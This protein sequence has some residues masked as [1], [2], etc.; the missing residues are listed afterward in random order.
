MQFLI[1]YTK[2]F[3]CVVVWKFKVEMILATIL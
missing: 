3:A 2:Y 1:L